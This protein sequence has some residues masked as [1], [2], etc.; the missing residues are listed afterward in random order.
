MNILFTPAKIGNLVIP[1]R[2]VRSAT[3]DAGAEDG[4]VSDW[5]IEL[6]RALSKGRVGLI[7]SGVFCVTTLNNAAPTLN[8]LTDDKHIAGLKRLSKVVHENGSKL[9]VQ[10][11]HPGRE[12]FRRLEPFGIEAVGP[13][14]VKSG[15]DPYFEGR[16]REM[17]VDEIWATVNAFGDATRRV[18]EAGCDGV[19]I[20][21]AHA[22][23]LAQF[24]SS[25]SNH[26]EDEWGGALENRLRLHKEIYRSAR[27]N[28]GP[29]YPLM[30]KLG[31]QDTFPGGLE[32]REG[33]P[34]AVQLAGIGYDSVEVSS[35]LRGVKWGQTEMR[36]KIFR[37]EREAYFREWA[38]RVKEEVDVPVMTVGGLRSLNLME[39]IVAGN[40]ADFV[41]LC[42]PLIREPGLVASWQDGQPRR[43][44]CISC[45]KCFEN[46]LSGHRLRCMITE[47]RDD[48]IPGR[49]ASRRQNG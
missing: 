35:G 32:F 34:A 39:E 2:F 40:D 45:N 14:G 20:H 5:Q 48:M 10:L 3:Y 6:Y 27:A 29:D 13:S 26:R 41:S 7:M 47:K 21:G 15:G 19:Q 43:P 8:L 1:N 9:A 16:C 38:R 23:L 12:A 24:L 49:P 28:I 25:Q 4:F 44:T 17:T 37:R 33:L 42:R 30:I 22:Y 18:Q 36:D 46:V 11:Y 31:V